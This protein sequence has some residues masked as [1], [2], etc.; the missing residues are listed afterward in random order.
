[1]KNEAQLNDAISEAHEAL[2]EIDNFD[3]DSSDPK[4]V[5]EMDLLN[6]IHE[7]A[8]KVVIKLAKKQ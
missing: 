5:A 7:M 4:S 3:L 6:K 8:L 1:M 2:E